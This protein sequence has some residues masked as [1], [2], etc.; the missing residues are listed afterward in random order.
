MVPPAKSASPQTAAAAIHPGY[1]FLSENPHF[2]EVCRECRIEFIGP[3]PEAM[4]RLGDKNQ[5]R[6]VAREV[7]VPIVP[8]TGVIE[9]DRDAAGIAA[10]IGYPVLIKAV[11]GGGGRGL[12]PVT[13]EAGLAEAQLAEAQL[14]EAMRRCSS[15]AAA[16][17]GDGR[18]YAERLMPR[19]RHVEVQV[20]G[21]GTGDVAVLGDRD[22]SL[23]RRRQKLIEI[24]P[25]AL[26]DGVRARLSAAAAKRGAGALEAALAL[27]PAV[28]ADAPSDLRRALVEHLRGQIAFDHRRG[29]EAARLL[30]SAATQLESLNPGLSRESYLEAL[31]AAIWESGPDGHASVVAAAKARAEP[32]RTRAAAEAILRMVGSPS[33][34]TS[35]FTDASRPPAG[36]SHLEA[37][38]LERRR[39]RAAGER[40]RPQRPGALPG[41]GRDHRLRPLA[42]GQVAP[43]TVDRRLAAV[44]RDRQLERPA[45]PGE[46]L[47]RTENL[48]QR[49]G[50]LHNR[51]DRAGGWRLLD[52]G[53]T[54]RMSEDIRIED[55]AQPQLDEAQRAALAWGETQPVELT[56][57]AVLARR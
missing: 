9:N 18:V 36:W 30:L 49:R 50:E 56:A 22:C 47:P 55:L 48:H 14:A 21:D 5:A 15:E 26:T 57:A 27:L 17:F 46:Q 11:A 13:S 3:T 45:E 7:G 38:E 32:A 44:D 25:A 33:R 4:H 31:A 29:G 51:P 40:P 42:G 23:Q 19:A 37:R 41:A 16:A 6:Q 54:A 20:A 39:D 1:G 10:Q 53:L 52:R 43:Q 35:R 12:R 2:A 28:E 24:A 34:L 8:G